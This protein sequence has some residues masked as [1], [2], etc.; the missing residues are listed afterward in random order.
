MII[1]TGMAFLSEVEMAVEAVKRAGND[2]FA[3]LHCV[4]NYPTEPKDVNLRAMATMNQAFGGPVGYSDHTDGIQIALA[5]VALGADLVEKHF[6]LDRSLPG[7]DHQASLEPKEFSEMVKGIR[8]VEF[9]LG[10]GCKRPAKS[11]TNSVATIRKS[12]VAVRDI[13]AGTI[14]TKELIGIKRPGTG[15][16]PTMRDA[17]LGRTVHTFVPAGRLF[18]FDCLE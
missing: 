4:T 17:L 10:D 9:A 13:P 6:T 8:Q 14:L 12:L 2:D 15:L 18:S 1:S 7:P 5:A 11:E 3:L 16:P